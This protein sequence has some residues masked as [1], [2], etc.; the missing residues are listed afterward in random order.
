MKIIAVLPCGLILNKGKSL[1]ALKFCPRDKSPKCGSV[2]GPVTRS[3]WNVSFAAH[4]LEF[5]YY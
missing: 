5:V 1:L 4:E 2:T 3:R